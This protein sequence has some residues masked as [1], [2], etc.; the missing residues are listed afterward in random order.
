MSTDTCK[1]K[2]VVHLATEKTKG[3]LGIICIPLDTTMTSTS[4]DKRGTK[5][6]VSSTIPKTHVQKKR[7]SS[8][9]TK[10][11]D[12]IVDMKLLFGKGRIMSKEYI[13]SIH[14]DM[15]S[16]F[17]KCWRSVALTFGKN[18]QYV[19]TDKGTNTFMKILESNGFDNMFWSY[20]PATIAR[21]TPRE[22]TWSKKITLLEKILEKYYQWK[23]LEDAKVKV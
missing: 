9:Q 15:C 7:K 11:L 17:K 13:D 4:V 23:K 2:T 6:K 20:L 8:R 1:S 18:G 10:C 12:M 16:G 3:N 14:E 19:S 22:P 5:R 21:L